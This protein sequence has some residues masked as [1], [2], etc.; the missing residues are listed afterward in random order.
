MIIIKPNNWTLDEWV[1]AQI[2]I[3]QL[4]IRKTYHW[5]AYDYCSCRDKYLSLPV[6]LLTSLVSTTAISQTASDENNNNMNYVISG[7]C[8]LITGLTSVGKYFNYAEAKEAHRQS[9][10]NYLRLR[11]ELAELL[12]T[13]HI[14]SDSIT[15]VEF[16]KIYYN[17]FISVRENA[18]TLPGKIRDLMDSNNIIKCNELKSTI[19]NRNSPNYIDSNIQI[20]KENT[21]IDI[22]VNESI[23]LNQNYDDLNHSNI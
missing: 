13:A 18:P 8:L 7:V 22:P 1:E 19:I 2:K 11:S 17:K 5:K 10:L 15:F 20:N 9:A 23:A 21:L 6:I 4:S 12:S 14:K 16:T 3:K